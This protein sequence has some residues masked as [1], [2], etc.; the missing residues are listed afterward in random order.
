VQLKEACVITQQ[1]R[2]DGALVGSGSD[3]DIV[4]FD[5]AVRGL[6]NETGPAVA[7]LQCD[8]RDPAADRGGDEGGIGR[9]EIRYLGA[10]GEAAGI[11]VRKWEIRQ[12]NRPVGKLKPQAVPAFGPPAFR[13]PVSLKHQ[14]RAAAL[15]QHVAHRQPGLAT[16]HDE[17]LDALNRHSAPSAKK[18]DLGCS[19]GLPN[20]FFSQ[21]ARMPLSTATPAKVLNFELR[22]EDGCQRHLCGV[23]ARAT[24]TAR[25]RHHAA[26]VRQDPVCSATG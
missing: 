17:C 4:G 2:N 13:D 21:V 24:R 12:S 6:G 19:A 26:H 10:G 11:G 3:N 16:A 18:R 14:M 20:G 8:D 1:R 22:I 25:P 9:Y 15:G 7:A 23:P 5:Q